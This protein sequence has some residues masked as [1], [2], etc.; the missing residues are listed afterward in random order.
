VYAIP[1]PRVKLAGKLAHAPRFLPV[2]LISFQRICNTPLLKLANV[3]VWGI[4]HGREVRSHALQQ[5]GSSSQS[6][7]SLTCFF[8][9]MVPS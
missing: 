1:A 7:N 8:W 5:R 9:F 2:D 4:R 6:R 3:R